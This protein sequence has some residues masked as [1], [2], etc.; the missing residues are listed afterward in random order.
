[1][2]RLAWVLAALAAVLVGC[3]G[4]DDSTDGNPGVASAEAETVTL[5][6]QVIAEEAGLGCTTSTARA[7]FDGT[8]SRLTV[9]DDDGTVIGTGT[10][11]LSYNAD[12]CNW[13]ATVDDVPVGA[14]FYR[15]TTPNGELATIAESALGPGARW[16]VDLAISVTGSITVT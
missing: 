5:D 7:G 11:G 2:S 16:T 15:L 14:G 12:S 3:G 4:D 1:M 8:G 9:T 10:F 13:T 6:V